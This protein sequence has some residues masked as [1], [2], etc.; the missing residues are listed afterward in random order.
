MKENLEGPQ[1][2]RVLGVG[3][4]GRTRCPRPT[5]R[6]Q[7]AVPSWLSGATG[8]ARGVP[9]ILRQMSPG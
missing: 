8:D 6:P 1:V 9:T 5:P 4:K 7:L 2:R 3:H